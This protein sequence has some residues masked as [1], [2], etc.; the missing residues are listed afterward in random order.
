M[1]LEELLQ[2]LEERRQKALAL[3]GPE[4]LAERKAAGVCC[5]HPSPTGSR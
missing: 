5:H 1:P 2:E 4:K 3:G